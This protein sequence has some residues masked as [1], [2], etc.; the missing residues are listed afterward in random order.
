M[1][2]RGGRELTPDPYLELV[3]PPPS[4]AWLSGVLRKGVRLRLRLNHGDGDRGRSFWQLVDLAAEPPRAGPPQSKTVFFLVLFCRGVVLRL[5]FTKGFFIFHADSPSCMNPAV[6]C[7]FVP[8]CAQAV[9][10]YLP[11]PRAESLLA[12]THL[13]CIQF[14]RRTYIWRTVCLCL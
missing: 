8:V 2:L 11:R 13:L 1:R 4:V 3:P 14:P 7:K 9:A 12:I 6:C 5:F 10:V